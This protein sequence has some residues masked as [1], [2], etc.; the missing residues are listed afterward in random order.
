MQHK[1]YCEYQKLI[2][3]DGVDGVVHNDWRDSP[4]EVLQAVNE[5]L[6]ALGLEVVMYETRSDQF[7]W[8]IEPRRPSTQEGNYLD[9][10]DDDEWT[11]SF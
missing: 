8:K 5:Q 7:A 4:E 2:E 9:V 1:T 6:E 10:T 11:G 3:A